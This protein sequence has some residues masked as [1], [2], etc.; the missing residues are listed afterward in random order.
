MLI[1]SWIFF[2]TLTFFI[3]FSI[4]DIYEIYKLYIWKI[5]GFVPKIGFFITH[6]LHKYL[7]KIYV[8][9][10]RALLQIFSLDMFSYMKCKIQNGITNSRY[11]F[12]LKNV[13]YQIQNMIKSLIMLFHIIN[14]IYPN[15][16][17]DNIF[18][19]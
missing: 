6:Y 11:K 1:S 14:P 5:T 19:C 7:K 9:T 12:L 4:C 8:T 10:I 18:L 15:R 16:K 3:Y 17:I 2:N 13:V